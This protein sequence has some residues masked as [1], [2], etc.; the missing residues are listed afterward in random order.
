MSLT[1][2]Q[3]KEYWDKVKNSNYQSSLRL[4]GFSPKLD[5]ATLEFL[6]TQVKNYQDKMWIGFLISKEKKSVK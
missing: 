5:L 1:L 3:K 6:Y 4:E 2:D